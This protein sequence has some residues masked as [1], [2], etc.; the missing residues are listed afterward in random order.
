M[1]AEIDLQA[2]ARPLRFIDLIEGI[3]AAKIAQTIARH[4]EM[5]RARIR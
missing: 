1:A 2:A 5:V 3:G 4:E